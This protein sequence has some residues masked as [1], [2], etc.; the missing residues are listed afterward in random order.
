MNS[1]SLSP[2]GQPDAVLQPESRLAAWRDLLAQCARK[3]SRKRVHGLRSLTLRLRMTLPQELP[4]EPAGTAAARAF[5][6]WSKAGRKL[7]KALEPVR[8]ADV[9]LARLGSLRDPGA[10][11]PADAAQPGPR[12]QREISLMESRL[13]RERQAD[14]E[15][16]TAVLDAGGKRLNRLSREME[17]AL[18]RPGLSS[19]STGQAAL[20]IFAG[21][22]REFP[23]LDS[24]NLHAYRKRLKQALYL[25]ESSAASDPLAARMA[26]AFRRIHDAAGEW[27]DWQALALE[28]S[29]LLPGKNN[30]DGLIPLLDALAEKALQRALVRCRRTAMR[31]LKNT[32]E[33]HP[34]PPRKPVASDPAFRSQDECLSLGISRYSGSPI[35]ML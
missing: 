26:A 33:A 31:F 19:H 21:M 27:H 14:S 5:R 23:T 1:D 4:G 11:T 29:Q 16:L 20:E 9:Y 17:A 34:G 18:A 13:R 15:K 3:P 12:C 7:R 8:N 35:A 24:G 25:A 28:A 6:R 10:Q 2:V 22:T 32:A 30:P